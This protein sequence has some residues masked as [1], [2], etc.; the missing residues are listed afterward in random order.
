MNIPIVRDY[1]L[2][3]FMWEKFGYRPHEVEELDVKFVSSMA[4][5]ASADNR[6]QR[7]RMEQRRH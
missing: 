4:A 5:V 1:N 7:E 2:Y 6:V 3:A